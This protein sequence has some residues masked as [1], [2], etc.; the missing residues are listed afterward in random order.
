M[1]RAEIAEAQGRLVE[2]ATWWQ[3][4]FEA[5]GGRS[6][7]AARGLARVLSARGDADGALRILVSTLPPVGVEGVTDAQ[8]LEDL[9]AQYSRIG[10][11]VQAIS[12]LE[13]AVG[14]GPG[15][16]STPILLAELLD[17]MG[18]VELAVESLLRS[19]GVRPGH[20]PTHLA[21]AGVLDSGEHW[22]P[23]LEEY[24]VAASLAPLGVAESLRATRCVLAL[25]RNELRVRWA[26]RVTAWLE[27]H[28]PPA[29]QHGAALR[30]LGELYLAS[31][32][33]LEAC[34]L[35][36]TM[37]GADPGD[38]PTILALVRAYLQSEQCQRA[39]ATAAHAGGLALTEP[40]RAALE[41]LQTAIKKA[42]EQIEATARENSGDD[43]R[44]S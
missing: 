4:A 10:E 15:R 42:A 39:Q 44:E 9:A 29:A 28:G 38:V 26:Q 14:L 41:E 19:V 12:A 34:A 17:E 36:E 35:L 3:E 21:L 33:A 37:A 43:Q 31:G 23:A 7:R 5:S 27:I 2:A 25:P 18:Q 13:V 30:A 6:T 32:K 16:P 24:Q 40:E 8:F 11:K 20:R 1:Q 22:L